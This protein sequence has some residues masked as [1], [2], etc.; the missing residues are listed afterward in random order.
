MLNTNSRKNDSHGP[1]FSPFSRLSVFAQGKWR[2]WEILRKRKRNL[3]SCPDPT[4]VPLLG[5]RSQS[6]FEWAVIWFGCVSS[7]STMIP[8]AL[9]GQQH[10]ATSTETPGQDVTGEEMKKKRLT[11]SEFPSLTQFYV[12]LS[13]LRGFTWL[14]QSQIY[15][16]FQLYDVT[17]LITPTH[18]P[19]FK[20]E[21]TFYMYTTLQCSWLWSMWVTASSAV[22]YRPGSNQRTH[23]GN[24][25][26]LIRIN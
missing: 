2:N 1:I 13:I 21:G 22:Q 16:K 18:L 6:Q 20:V 11:N 15:N 8:L 4:R 25:S 9:S 7:L 5:S 24:W 3:A 26:Q 12:C 17:S 23:A 19:P 10:G 14:P